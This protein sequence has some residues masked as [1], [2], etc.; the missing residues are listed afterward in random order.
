MKKKNR[1]MAKRIFDPSLSPDQR[2]K[3]GARW[4]HYLGGHVARKLNRDLLA[5]IIETSDFPSLFPLK[6]IAPDDKIIFP[7]RN[8]QA[9]IEPR[10]PDCSI[11]HSIGRVDYDG[12]PDS[13]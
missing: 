10:V 5:R 7:K 8:A 6:A 11:R 13:V 2:C 9:K 3:A 1:L 12:N 4:G